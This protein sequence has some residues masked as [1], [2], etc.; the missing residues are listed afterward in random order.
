MSDPTASTSALV[1]YLDS[2]LDD[3]ALHRSLHLDI[4]DGVTRESHPDERLSGE[5]FGRSVAM[6]GD[7]SHLDLATLVSDPCPRPADTLRKTEC[8]TLTNM[9]ENRSSSPVGRASSVDDT[10]TVR[11]MAR[12]TFTKADDNTNH[13]DPS[14]LVIELAA[15]DFKCKICSAQFVAYGYIMKHLMSRHSHLFGN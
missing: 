10:D 7:G 1:D 5:L 12:G 4:G 8:D 3:I 11:K 2:L 15:D 14:S 13:N 9:N 6:H